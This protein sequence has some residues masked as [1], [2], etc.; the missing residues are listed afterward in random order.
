MAVLRLLVHLLTV[1]VAAH[2]RLVRRG[3]VL[4]SENER[5][6][7]RQ[8]ALMLPVVVHGERHRNGSPRR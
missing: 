1:S 4:G 5:H 8:T 2:T 6:A 3:V 7:N